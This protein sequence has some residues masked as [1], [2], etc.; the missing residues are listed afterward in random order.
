MRTANVWTDIILFNFV[1]TT[2]A[3]VVCRVCRILI[4]GLTLMDR[5]PGT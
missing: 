4:D 3:W 5:R 2:V 1:G